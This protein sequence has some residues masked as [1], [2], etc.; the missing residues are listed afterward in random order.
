MLRNIYNF[1]EKENQLGG[2]LSNNKWI[3]QNVQIAKMFK[4][5]CAWEYCTI[6]KTFG[7]NRFSLT[8]LII[9][10]GENQIAGWYKTREKMELWFSNTIKNLNNSVIVPMGPNWVP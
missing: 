4:E 9:F 6:V 2:W 10:W 3:T 7:T 5:Q 1:D 8:L